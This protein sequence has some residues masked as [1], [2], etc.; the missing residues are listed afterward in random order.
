MADTEALRP[1]RSI[2]FNFRDYYYYCYLWARRDNDIDQFEDPGPPI[3]VFVQCPFTCTPCR[4]PHAAV[5][6]M[7]HGH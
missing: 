5:S 2:F 4:G 1:P 7:G 3:Q 6:A